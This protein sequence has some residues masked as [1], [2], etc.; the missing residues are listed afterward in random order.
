MRQLIVCFA[1][2][3]VVVNGLWGA[4]S[5]GGPAGAGGGG[6]GFGEISGEANLVSF[7]ESPIISFFEDEFSKKDIKMDISFFL[8]RFGD[9][10]ASDSDLLIFLRR[11]RLDQSFKMKCLL[12]EQRFNKPDMYT[13]LMN[14][15]D[16]SEYYEYEDVYYDEDCEDVDQEDGENDDGDSYKDVDPDDADAI[17]FALLGENFEPCNEY[18]D[19][20]AESTDEKIRYDMYCLHNAAATGNIRMIERCLYEGVHVDE[21]DPETG[22]A[23]LHCAFLNNEYE[24]AQFLLIKGA[25]ILLKDNKSNL[26]VHIAVISGNFY[27]VK[28]LLNKN[29]SCINEQNYLGQTPLDVV[30]EHFADSFDDFVR[31]FVQDLRGIGFKRCCQLSLEYH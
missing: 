6:A 4:E 11:A 3:V 12:F 8:K 1:L 30:F 15:K 7:N 2:G 31:E 27:I 20:F 18:G 21:R 24:V 28:N 16:E 25:N 9:V 22:Y 13:C 23:A 29:I 5:S 10:K 19:F 26:P 17:F 14:K